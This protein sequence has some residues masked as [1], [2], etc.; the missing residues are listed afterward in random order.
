MYMYLRVDSQKKK[1]FPLLN[2]LKDYV[3]PLLVPS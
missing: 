1:D 2:L 3:G